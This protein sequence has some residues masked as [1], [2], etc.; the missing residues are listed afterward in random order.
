MSITEF[1]TLIKKIIELGFRIQNN[2]DYAK[3]DSVN[4][5]EIKIKKIVKIIVVSNYSA[6]SSVFLE[7][8]LITL[9]TSLTTI[10][11]S[12]FFPV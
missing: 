1:I 10:I 6:D 8:M 3:T 7:A 12:P 2:C 4:F 5:H 9:A 11:P